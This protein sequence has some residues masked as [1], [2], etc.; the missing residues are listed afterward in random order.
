MIEKVSEVLGKYPTPYYLYDWEG[1]K[2]RALLLK[3]FFEK[4]TSIHYAM[5]ANSNRLLL[6]RF[7]GLGLGVDTVSGGEIMRALDCGY[8]PNQ[9]IFSGVGKSES[10]I[11]L[12]LVTGIKQINVESPSELIRIGKLARELN[13]PAPVAFR[14]NPDVNANTHPYITTGFRENKFGMEFDFLPELRRILRE[15]SE[16]LSLVGVTLHIGS[17]LLE[18]TAIREAIQKTKVIWF[19]LVREG[20]RLKTFDVGGGLGIAYRDQEYPPSIEDYSKM[21][22]EEL[23]SLGCEILL[24]PGRWLVGPYG[25]LVAQVEYVKATNEKNFAIVNTGMHHLMRPSLYQAYHEIK[26]LTPRVPKELKLYDV[27]GPICESSDVLGRARV[28]PELFEGDYLGIWNAGAYGFVMASYYN[29]HEM[30]KEY[31]I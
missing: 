1:L 24:E 2:N 17:Q 30:P 14:L 12:A 15:F 11:R 29:L 20:Y 9:I 16:S 5:K 27:V 4:K 8:K 13:C 28:L 25:I 18:L 22:Y 26:L 7:A 3:S 19:Q 31:F 6:K 23:D 21:V 10:E